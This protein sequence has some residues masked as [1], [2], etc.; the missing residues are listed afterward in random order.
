MKMRLINCKPVPT[1]FECLG[2]KRLKR[3][4]LK[5]LKGNQ[6]SC[7][8]RAVGSLQKEIKGIVPNEKCH[9]RHESS[10]F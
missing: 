3:H 6:L 5:A 1:A 7:G 8:R 10:G 4:I 2:S 9:C